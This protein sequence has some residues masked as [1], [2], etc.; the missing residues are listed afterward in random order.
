MMQAMHVARI[1]T[2]E[3]CNFRCSFCVARRDAERAVIAGARSIRR[4]ID[5]AHAAGVRVLVLTGGEPTLR[6]DLLVIVRYAA[7]GGT[8]VVLETNGARISLA[9]AAELAQAGVVTARVHAPVWG[10]ALDEIAGVPGAS[11]DMRSGID[12]LAR[13]GIAIELSVPLSAATAHLARDVPAGAAAAKLSID[14]IVIVPVIAAP[15]PSE[16][17]PIAALTQLA[18]QV[19]RA[20]KHAGIAAR[21]SVEPFVPPCAFDDPGEVAHLYAM[22]PGGKTRA[23]YGR[24]A[25]CDG[26]AVKDRCPGVS[27]VLPA[28]DPLRRVRPLASDR[29]RRRLSI[30]S[31]VREQI[32]RELVTRE[33]CRRTDGSSIASHTVRVNFHC[34]QACRFCFVSTHLPPAEHA[35]I[36]AAI[37]EIGALGGILALSGGEP[38]LNPRLL[39]YVERGRD[40]GA[41]EIELQTN[42]TRLAGTDLAHRLSDTGVSHAIVSLHGATAETSD[43]ITDAPGTFDQT[44]LGLDALLQTPIRVRLNYVFCHANRSEFPAYVDMVAARWPGVSLTISFVASSTDVVPHTRELMPRYADVMPFLAEGVRRARVAG[45]NVTGFE[46]MCGLP[47][48][49]VPEDVTAYA[50]LAEI[51]AGLDRGEFLKPAPCQTCEASARCFG[52]RR[53]YAAL[54]GTDELTPIRT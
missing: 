17:L 16:V 51:P 36:V 3:T 41:R 1:V 33:V 26:C 37:D 21:F 5:E 8:R 28:E 30:I 14:H 43:F 46:S 32:Q 35:A 22:T 12:A 23:G 27:D 53:G 38:T 48:C 15:H 13:A 54:H 45:L 31:S 4:R 2:N 42:A 29:I 6:R 18:V 49:L 47:L 20:S 34:N 39:E 11:I 7:R 52:V 19:A 24:L 50:G 10:D 44:L 40:A 25:G 9:F